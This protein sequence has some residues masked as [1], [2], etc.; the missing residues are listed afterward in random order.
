MKIEKVVEKL[1]DR[2]PAIYAMNWDNPGLQVGKSS[3]P[4]KK[5]MVALDATNKENAD[6]GNNRNPG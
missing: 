5:I 4:V 1:A 3:H 6:S 2:Y